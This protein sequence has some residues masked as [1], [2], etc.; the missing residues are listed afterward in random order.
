MSVTP[1]TP[2]ATTLSSGPSD[3]EFLAATEPFRREII[4]HCYRMM[5][6]HHD[7]EDLTQETYLRA[8]RG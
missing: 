2:P 5:G 7:A 3:A 4:A 1:A 6:S 8:G